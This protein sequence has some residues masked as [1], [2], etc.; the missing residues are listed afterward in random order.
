LRRTRCRSICARTEKVAIVIGRRIGIT[1]A[2]DKPW[3]YGR[4]GSLFL[5]KPF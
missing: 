1:K 4:P 3:R 5:S 2:A